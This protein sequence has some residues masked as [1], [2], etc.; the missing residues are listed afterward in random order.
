M[1]VRPNFG[2]EDLRFGLSQ[3]EVIKSIG[4]PEQVEPDDYGNGDS[5]VA[6]Y[7]WSKG[8]SLHFD[9]YCDFRLECIEVDA[10]RAVF[11]GHKVENLSQEALQGL[12]NEL[13]LAWKADQDGCL[14]VPDLNMNFWFEN[15]LPDAVQWSVNINENDIPE[16]PLDYQP[17]L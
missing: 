5:T 3:E 15:G 13:G 4:E 1:E 17:P 6:W 2:L 14:S 11:Q 9:S 10:D 7:Y 12:L 16:W 8:F